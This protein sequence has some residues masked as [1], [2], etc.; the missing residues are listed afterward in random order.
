M[1]TIGLTWSKDSASDVD[2]FVK[3]ADGQVISLKRQESTIGSLDADD[4]GIKRVDVARREVISIKTLMP[5]RYTVNVLL[6]KNGDGHYVVAQGRAT[7]MQPFSA[8]CG[9]E[10]QLITNGQE[11]TICSFDVDTNGDVV[12]VDNDTQ[13][14]IAKEG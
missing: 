9:K 1:K 8:I 11:Q 6:Y 3:G 7:K 2:L 5:G 14:G 4:N 10:V 13:Y 12:L